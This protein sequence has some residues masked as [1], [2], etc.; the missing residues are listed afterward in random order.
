MASTSPLLMAAAMWAAKLRDTVRELR[1]EAHHRQHDG[2][3]ERR[4][5]HVLPY[6]TEVE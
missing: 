5:S 1:S 3:D 4:P 6:V 2:D